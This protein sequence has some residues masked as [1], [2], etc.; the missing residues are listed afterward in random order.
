MYWKIGSVIIVAIIISTIFSGCVD[1][2]QDRDFDGVNDNDD[3]DPNIDVFIAITIINIKVEDKIDPWPA[4]EGELYIKIKAKTG[5]F[6]KEETTSEIYYQNEEAYLVPIN[7]TFLYNMPDDEETVDL[8]FTVFDSD[9]GFDDKLDISS[10]GKACDIEYNLLTHSF[11]GDTSV[12]VT[13]GND[14]GTTDEDD[15]DVTVRF[16]IVDNLG[17]TEM[18]KEILQYT[19]SLEGMNITK[20]DIIE[21]LNK[22]LVSEVESEIKE[23]LIDEILDYLEK[24][25]NVLP[26]LAKYGRSLNNAY[27]IAC[28]IIYLYQNVYL[29]NND[30]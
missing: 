23:E 2:A 13:S 30:L 26:F 21:N 1:A 27:S 9:T 29:G 10:D 15:N 12:N 18:I 17:K 28:V 6:D 7:F 3:I 5:W 24:H 22:F 25:P 4:E 14:D 19:T 11:S 20:E 16:E 8:T